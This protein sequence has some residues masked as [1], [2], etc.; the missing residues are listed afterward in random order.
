LAWQ[1]KLTPGAEKELNRLDLQAARIILKYLKER[2]AHDPRAFG[3]RLKGNLREFWRYRVGEYRILTKIQD[4]QVL[5]L[6][7]RIAHRGKVYKQS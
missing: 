3:E 2:V 4:D 5:V 1:I 6:V 7:V